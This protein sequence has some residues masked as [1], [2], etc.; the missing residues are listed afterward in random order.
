MKYQHLWDK[1]NRVATC[2]YITPD[3][4][5]FIGKAK[6]HPDDEEFCSCY[7]GGNIAEFR[8]L[9]KYQKYLKQQKMQEV[10]ALR[11]FQSMIQQSKQYNSDSYEAKMLNRA[12][13]ET[14]QEIEDIKEDMNGL[15]W[16][17]KD[18]IKKSDEAHRRIKRFEDIHQRFKDKDKEN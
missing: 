18:Y 17:E 8:A 9:Y 6:C 12:I 14:V 11:H 10:K 13:N 15:L 1:E 3:G 4:H 16:Y 2:I 5:H 7:T